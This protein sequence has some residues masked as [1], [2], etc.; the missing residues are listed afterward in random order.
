[1]NVRLHLL[2]PA[3]VVA[4]QLAV[5][6]FS[7]LGN[8][9][10]AQGW[11]GRAESLGAADDEDLRPWYDLVRG[12]ISPD[13]QMAVDLARRA[14][15]DGRRLQDRDLELCAL[16]DLGLAL[17]RSGIVAEGLALIDEG[18]AGTLAGE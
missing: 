12:Y 13:I 14:L 11:L 9:V 6:F 8:D 7:S 15:E 16:C 3:V 18:M 4:L 1:M 2:V 5:V 17:V 10:A